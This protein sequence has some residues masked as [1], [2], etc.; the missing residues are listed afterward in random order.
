MKLRRAVMDSHL[1]TMGTD[2]DSLVHS[3]Q[4]KPL[5]TRSQIEEFRE[6]RH[7]LFASLPANMLRDPRI[8]R[9]DQQLQRILEQLDR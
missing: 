7:L 9:L 6:S 5:L 4:F 1:E 2:M 8:T 3:N